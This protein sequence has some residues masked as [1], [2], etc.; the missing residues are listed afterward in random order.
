MVS[1][2]IVK[3]KCIFHWLEVVE[4]V[5]ELV[6]MR[7]I[8]IDIFS[9]GRSTLTDYHFAF[10]VEQGGTLGYATSDYGRSFVKN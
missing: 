9:Q 7:S 5:N 10:A 8:A 1:V 6:T 4:D 3:G 2:E